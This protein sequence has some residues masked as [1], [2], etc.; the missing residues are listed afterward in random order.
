MIHA[1][2]KVYLEKARTALGRMLDFAVYDLK[3]DI[4]KFFDMFIKSGIA[5]QFELGD[6]TLLVGMSGVELAYRVLEQSGIYER[7]KPNYSVNRSEEFWTGWAL[8][9][10]QWET[11]LGFAEIVRCVPIRDI[12]ALYSP[13]HEMDIRQF[14]D[15]M[16]DLYKAA[17]P[18]TNLKRLRQKAGLS[19]RE[20]AELSGIP[21]RMI[22]QYE[23]RRKNINKAHAEYLVKLTR[24]LYCEVE[25]LMEKQPETM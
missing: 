1:Y 10:Y 14:V 20:L 15:K 24:L 13:Y 12:V 18:E 4:T 7:I 2:D 19:Q 16:N 3:Y 8:A 11:S 6:F 23:Q 22:Q 21:V 5:A 25:D 9:Y 17:N